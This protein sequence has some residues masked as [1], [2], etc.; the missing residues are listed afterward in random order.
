[1]GCRFPDTSSG[2]DVD[3]MGSSLGT[4]EY[5]IVL[6][7]ALLG[8]SSEKIFNTKWI[9]PDTASGGRAQY[10]HR[11]ISRYGVKGSVRLNAG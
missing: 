6:I 11:H 2:M 8:Q 1:M 5:H 7:A 4:R 10:I 9:K 3:Q